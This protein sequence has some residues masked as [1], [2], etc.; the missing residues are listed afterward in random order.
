ML[1]NRNLI[2]PFIVLQSLISLLQLK[3]IVSN[4]L[5]PGLLVNFIPSYDPINF[6]SFDISTLV[7]AFSVMIAWIVTLKL[8]ISPL[9]ASLNSVGRKWPL[10]IF[11]RNNICFR[12][13]QKNIWILII[14]IFPRIFQGNTTI[15]M[16][17]YFLTLNSTI[18]TITI[19][20]SEAIRSKSIRIH[21]NLIILSKIDFHTKRYILIKKSISS[22][23]SEIPKK[24][25]TMT[26]YAFPVCI[27][28]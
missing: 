19:W 4:Y 18:C 27:G 24:N 2:I 8:L 14:Y 11:L 6:K 3:K 1:W 21:K 15:L 9:L 10:Q 16:V 5:T 20:A 17:S 13:V 25:E 28:T 26:Q 22:K 23:V 12:I 7:S